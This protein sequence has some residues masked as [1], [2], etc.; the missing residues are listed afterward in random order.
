[1]RGFYV[2]EARVGC[3]C[4]CEYELLHQLVFGSK[5]RARTK[6]FELGLKCKVDYKVQF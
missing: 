3:M 5:I 6:R 2:F 4:E 1:M